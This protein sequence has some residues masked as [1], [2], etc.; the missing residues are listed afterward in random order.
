MSL[1]YWYFIFA[2][3]AK[4]RRKMIARE[5]SDFSKATIETSTNA[6][7]QKKYLDWIARRIS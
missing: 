3:T 4:L 1:F 7:L 2:L 6:A 5:L